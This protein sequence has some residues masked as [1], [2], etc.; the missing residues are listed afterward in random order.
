MSDE[1]AS[2]QNKTLFP[3][4][5]CVQTRCLT[6]GEHTLKHAD[7]LM[8]QT[9]THTH[10]LYAHTCM[11]TLAHLVNVSQRSMLSGP[12]GFGSWWSDTR[13]TF[14]LLWPLHPSHAAMESDSTLEASVCAQVRLHACACVH[15]EHKT[16]FDHLWAVRSTYSLCTWSVTGGEF[17]KG[18]KS[19]QEQSCLLCQGTKCQS[20]GKTRLVIHFNIYYSTSCFPT[21][22]SL[23]LS[24]GTNNKGYWTTHSSQHFQHISF[25]C[26]TDQISSLVMVPVWLL[27]CKLNIEFKQHEITGAEG[28]DLAWSQNR[29]LESNKS[30]ITVLQTVFMQCL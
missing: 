30:C 5:E 27:P 12:S 28:R 13:W 23:I 3:C 7:S 21:E 18:K 25:C 6:F 14:S 17:S 20:A 4:E 24:C 29:W 11:H 1:P 26:W 15:I 2:W 8:W 22:A 16:L 10:T 19:H 9:H